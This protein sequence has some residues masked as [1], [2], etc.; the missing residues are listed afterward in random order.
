MLMFLKLLCNAVSVE[1]SVV[2][3]KTTNEN[4]PFVYL[5]NDSQTDLQ[6]NKHIQLVAQRLFPEAII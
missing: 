3:F 1:S 4:A 2:V 6:Y 5:V